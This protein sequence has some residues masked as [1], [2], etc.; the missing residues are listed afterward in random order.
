MRRY[1]GG[2]LRRSLMIASLGAGCSTMPGA[3]AQTFTDLRQMSL[4]Q[5]SQ[6]DI[7]SV[8][9]APQAIGEAPA[10]IYVIS[11]NDIERSGATTIPEALRL[12]P[13]LVVARKLGAFESL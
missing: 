11:N 2:W 9:K 4:A 1:G 3:H 6:V 12:A 13:N 8:T 7:S 10:A 5:L